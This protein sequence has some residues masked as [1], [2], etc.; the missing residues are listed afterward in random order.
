M[1]LKQLLLL[2]M[3]FVAGSACAQSV[4]ETTYDVEKFL[5]EHGKFSMLPAKAFGKKKAEKSILSCA[6]IAQPL[7]TAGAVGSDGQ[8][9]ELES[10]GEGEYLMKN[11]KGCYLT[12]NTSICADK[13]RAAHVRL[14]GNKRSSF[15]GFIISSDGKYLNDVNGSHQ[16]FD[17]LACKD[18]SYLT[19]PNYTFYFTTQDGKTMDDVTPI[20]SYH[21]KYNDASNW[22]NRDNSHRDAT[23]AVFYEML[24]NSG[25]G[26]ID[27]A[28]DTKNFTSDD[29]HQAIR[30]I[31]G[32]YHYAASNVDQSS[33]KFSM[34]FNPNGLSED[35]LVAQ[36][37]DYAFSK[38]PDF[39]RS[40]AS[41]EFTMKLKEDTA[42]VSMVEKVCAG[43]INYVSNEYESYIEKSPSL[44]LKDPT[45]AYAVASWLL[46]KQRDYY[47]G[48]WDL[49][50]RWSWEAIKIMAQTL[51]TNDDYC[52]I[53]EK[54]A[55]D[56]NERF[57]PAKL[58][59]IKEAASWE[60]SSNQIIYS[61]TEDKVYVGESY[62]ST[63]K[64]FEYAPFDKSKFLGIAFSEASLSGKEAPEY[65]YIGRNSQAELEKDVAAY[66]KKSNDDWEANR[67]ASIAKALKEK[68]QQEA[69][70][71]SYLI[72][73][74]GS[75]A[76]N[77]ME[78]NSPYVGMPSAIL[79]EYGWKV[80]DS[81]GGRTVYRYG[82]KR[83]LA[84]N[85]VVKSV[86][87]E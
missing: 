76:Y 60:F 35:S 12:S 46:Y 28:L 34:E 78:R 51:K 16:K 82:R 5:V 75:K 58:P 62:N 31:M 59:E 45:P 3:L 32:E 23:K 77:A 9:W 7:S 57:I 48:G 43:R 63:G 6:G 65:F 13:A 21:H 53:S 39:I 20:I 85:G 67:A 61:F 69:Q 22:P 73:K 18:K 19:D 11:E 1:K 33:V 25:K 15:S 2:V 86:Y 30:F 47:N 56:L 36:I 10:D 14:I 50:Q 52:I 17:W 4:K 84:I 81:F 40:S 27:V 54:R 44:R 38:L 83:C 87:T 42:F 68:A 80:K 29:L 64:H 24:K 26:I 71:K 49:S 37:K 70:I 8:Y 55:V 74:Y 72:G 66:H 79:T 41:S